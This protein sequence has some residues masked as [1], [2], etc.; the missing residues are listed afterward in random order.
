[1]ILCDSTNGGA[2]GSDELK[3]QFWEVRILRNHM[4]LYQQTITIIVVRNMLNCGDFNCIAGF[5]TSIIDSLET[6]FDSTIL[7]ELVAGYKY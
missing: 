3:E 2:E 6:Y 1:M 4:H 5:D 7:F